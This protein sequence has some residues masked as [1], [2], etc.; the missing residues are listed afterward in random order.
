LHIEASSE[1]NKTVIFHFLYVPALNTDLVEENEGLVGP[2]LVFNG[3]GI[4]GSDRCDEERGEHFHPDAQ[5]F[6]FCSVPPVNIRIIG[7]N[8]F[9]SI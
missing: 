1:V 5:V 6:V 3:S 4:I 9:K 8:F 2:I 7:I